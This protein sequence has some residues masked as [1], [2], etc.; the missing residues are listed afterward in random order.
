MKTTEEIRDFLKK[1]GAGSVVFIGLNE[2]ATEDSVIEDA[3]CFKYI[4]GRGLW[5]DGETFF[6][7]DQVIELNLL[8]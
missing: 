2:T 1:A 6:N 5:S 7:S 3:A 8:E 4:E